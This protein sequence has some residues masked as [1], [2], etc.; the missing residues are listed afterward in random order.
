MKVGENS[1]WMAKTRQRD[2][3]QTQAFDQ[4]VDCQIGGST[5]ENPFTTANKLSDD[6]D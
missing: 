5:Y 3:M 1:G 2:L 4:V 6:F